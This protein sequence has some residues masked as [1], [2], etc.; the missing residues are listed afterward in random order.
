MLNPKELIK[1]LPS[2]WSELTLKQYQQLSE[3]VI[4][5]EDEDEIQNLTIGQDNTLK[6][7]SMLT[8]VPIEQLEELPF[9]DLAVLASKLAFMQKPPEPA[10]KSSIQF[11]KVDEI[12]YNDYITFLA[13]AKEP[14]KN[15]HIIIKA[16]NKSNL[17][18]EQIQELG[19]DDVMQGFQLLQR[20]VNKYMRR[21]IR[22]T[23]LKLIKQTAVEKVKKL[24]H[25][26]VRM[27]R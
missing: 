22:C 19:M 6:V 10:K 16:F 26:K 23:A 12:S 25:F 3:V 18:D 9:H 17:T 11:K 27:K 15:L 4:S 24:L 8:G 14:F 20:Y 1:Q 21:I 13:L 7:I 5:E 2:S